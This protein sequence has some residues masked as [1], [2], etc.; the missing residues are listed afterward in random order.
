MRS[1]NRGD[2]GQDTARRGCKANSQDNQQEA[3][4]CV[5]EAEEKATYDDKEAGAFK[6]AHLLA[7]LFS[8]PH[9]KDLNRERDLSYG[10]VLHG[11]CGKQP[12]HRFL[13][14]PLAGNGKQQPLGA[15]SGHTYGCSA[16]TLTCTASPP[17]PSCMPTP[18][19]DTHSP[20]APE[21][22]C[23]PLTPQTLAPPGIQSVKQPD[24]GAC[25]EIPAH[26]LQHLLRTAAAGNPPAPSSSSHKQCLLLASCVLPDPAA[27][28]GGQQLCIP[29]L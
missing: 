14:L 26:H 12:G 10:G 20:S 25:V 4:Q 29:F 8:F 19:P 6:K 28:S 13:Q 5:G 21:P 23:G 27:P 11:S 16:Q 1:R 2:S 15:A 9:K 22:S 18:S 7:V 17:E 3:P 24:A